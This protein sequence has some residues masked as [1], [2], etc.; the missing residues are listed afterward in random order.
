MPNL[1]LY[2]GNRLELLAEKLAEVLRLLLADPLKSEVIVV[3]SKGMERWVSLELARHQGIC[4]NIQFPFPNTFVFEVFRQIVPDVQEDPLFEPQIM[5]WKIMDILP[6]CLGA[7]GFESLRR[8]LDSDRSDLKRFQ[9]SLRIAA[10]FDQYLLFRPDLILSWDQGADDQWQA[11]L[12]RRLVKGNETNHR[13]ALQKTFLEKIQKVLPQT[14]KNLPD[15]ISV[16]GISALPPFHLQVL[17]ALS[18]LIEVNLFLMNP[19]RE[20]WGDIF[21]KR[22]MKR[23]TKRQKKGG[24]SPEELHLEKGNSLLASMGMLGRDFFDLIT[25]LGCQEKEFFSDP[26]ED[27]L[28]NSIQSDVLNL[29]D[30]GGDSGQKKE[31]R[32]FDTSIQVDSCHSP[33]REV[34]VIQDRLLALFESDPTLFPKDILVMAPDIE[35]YAP[36]IQAVF[37]LPATDPRWIPFSIADRGVRKES[38]LIDAFLL[39]LDLQGSRLGASEVLAI[40]ESQ[41]VQRRFSLV[42]ADLEPIHRWVRDTRIRW[43]I[44]EE[45]R[46]ELGLPAFSENTWRAGLKRMLLGVA[47]PRQEDQLFMG[48]LPYDLIEG[49]GTIVLGNFLG[50]MEH[51]FE[52]VKELG[53]A[54]TLE[55][56]GDFLSGLLENFFLP[57][58]ETEREA[59]IIRR[60]LSDLSG[61][62]EL[63]GFQE[64]VGLE[65]ISDYLRT[66]LEQEGFGFGFLTGGLTFCAMLPMR[67]IPFRVICLMGMND[68]TYPRQFK[69]LGFDL[70][71]KNPRPGDRSRRKDD[72]YLFLEALLSA[73][74][75]FFISYGGQSIQ[76]NSLRPPSVL[77]SELLD[78]VEQGYAVAGKKILDQIIT[79]HHLQAFSPEY[80][81]KNKKLLSYSKE[82]FEAAQCAGYQRREPLPFILKA[83]PEPSEGWKI[84]DLNQFGHFFGNPARVFLQRRLGIYLDEEAGILDENEPFD[85]SG[86]ERYQLEQYLV[87]KG[88]QKQTLQESLPAVR[89]SGQLPHGTPGKSL[90][91]Q[92]CQGLKSFSNTVLFY[93]EKDAF[94]PLEVDCTIEGFRLMGRID[95]RYTDGIIHYRYARM[96]PQERLRLWIDLHLINLLKAP[97]HPCQGILICKDKTCRVLPAEESEKSLK[98]LIDLYWQG[99]TKPLHFFPRSSWAYAESLEKHG[100]FEKA[101]T[102]ARKTWEGDFG[103]MEKE[104]PYFQLCFGNGDPLDEEF[105]N[106]AREILG[107]LVG[108][109]EKI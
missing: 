108:S 95:Q 12:W 66:C 52:A 8:Y 53:Q 34:E 107:P 96:R 39:L 59:Q 90:F 105:E 102:A 68:D 91:D 82:N 94:K 81:K 64:K 9:L 14:I 61:R 11:V 15:R 69:S 30:R 44:D 22:E 2:T 10:L 70:I 46:K 80:F 32:E 74:E 42:D 60:T 25:G 89:A 4:A 62:Q 13:A 21:S 20:Y 67:S 1:N 47:L 84:I 104:D 100:D 63:S 76:D 72:R 27:C 3:Q 16:F 97:E 106:L 17:S 101:K 93:T 51:L 92:T 28:L 38:R 50:F 99:L 31:I 71:A 26:G 86:L 40:L 45:S 6:S 5:T 7:Q 24:V 19:C 109:E 83:L 98:T 56:W 78:Y 49:E 43:G 41:A 103:P 87:K 29:L 73:R 48:I 88:L 18:R 54:R 55:E 77:V 23:V 85:L 36:F 33:M 35:T 57:D 75:R 79:R 58:E 37:S 65:V